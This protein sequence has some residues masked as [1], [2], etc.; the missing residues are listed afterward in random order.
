[1]VL[2][3]KCKKSCNPGRSNI[4]FHPQYCKRPNTV[5]CEGVL[6]VQRNNCNISGHQSNRNECFK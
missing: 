2:Q 6:R 5:H 3:Y 1:M 4:A